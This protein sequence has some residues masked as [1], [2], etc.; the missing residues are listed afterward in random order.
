[1]QSNDLMKISHLEFVEVMSFYALLT[2]STLSTVST[3]S[4][5]FWYLNGILLGAKNKNGYYV[6]KIKYK[7]FKES[8]TNVVNNRQRK[9]K[10]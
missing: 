8:E 7:Q 3:N 10:K 2:P 1:M 4:N 6:S 9:N 5:E